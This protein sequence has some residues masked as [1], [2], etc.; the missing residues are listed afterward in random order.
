MKKLVVSLLMFL[1]MASCATTK[2]QV[3]HRYSHITPEKIRSTCEADNF[4]NMQVAGV[5]VVV[6]H[7]DQCLGVDNMLVM[8]TTTNQYTKEIRSHSL[9]LLGLHYLEFLKAKKSD[10]IWNLE[11]IK[12]YTVSNEGKDKHNEWF[13]VYKVKSKKA[14][15]CSGPV[16][17]V[18]K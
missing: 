16:C 12:E 10:K 4:W 9:N 6:V 7:F 5:A 18:K 14:A 15:E 1:L 3:K 2:P 13:V 11:K 17:K 8:V